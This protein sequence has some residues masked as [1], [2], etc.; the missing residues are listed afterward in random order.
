MGIDF[1]RRVREAIFGKDGGLTTEDYLKDYQRNRFSDYLPWVQYIP[2]HHCYQTLDNRYGYFFEITPF[3]FQ[4]SQ[5]TRAL[6]SLLQIDYPKKSIL[7]IILTPSVNCDDQIDAFISGKVR[8]DPLAQKTV[9]E[10]AN[11]LR[12]GTRGLNSLHG[13]PVRNFRAFVTLKT[14]EPL[15]EPVYATFHETLKN[16]G[17]AP[18]EMLPGSLV[19][20]A[21]ELFND[22]Y[23]REDETYD[24]YLPLRKQIIKADT[25]IDFTDQPFRVGNRYGA[26]LTPKSTRKDINPL[27]TNELIGGY[28]GLEDDTRQISCAFIWSVNIL[29]DDLRSSLSTKASVTLAQKAPGSFAKA[30]A[31]RV[32]EFTW[33]LDV[34]ETERFFTVI[35]S[36][37][38]LGDSKQQTVEMSSRVSNIWDIKNFT[39]QQE[40]ILAKTLFITSLPMGLYDIKNNINLLDRHFYMPTSALA[41]FMPVQ[42][43]FCGGATNPALLYIGRKGQLIGVDVFDDLSN[44][45]N[46]FCAA[47]SGS[48]KS[49]N[50]NF[51]LNAYY[52]SN[53]K[54][55]VVDLGG[56]YEKSAKTNKGRFMEFGKERT[57]INPF[58]THAIDKEDLRQDMKVTATIIAEMAYS[59]SRQ[60]LHETEWTL[61]KHAVEWAFETGQTINGIDAVRTFL[62]SFPKHSKE[63]LDYPDAEKM[64]HALAFNLSDFSTEGP[65][66][67]Y[68]NGET[69]FDIS[70]D[71]YV[72]LE[73]EKL[74]GDQELFNVIIMQVMNSV[75]QD[76]YLSDRSQRRFILFEEAWQYFQEGDQNARIATII[77]EG[78]RRARKYGGAFGIVVQSPLDLLKFG[79]IGKVINGNAAYKFFLESSDYRAAVEA[80]ILEY[81]GLAI[82]ILEKVKNVKPRYSEVF[83]QTPFG[84]GVARLSVDEWN[85]VVNSSEGKDRKAFMDILD[86]GKTPYEAIQILSGVQ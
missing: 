82:D 80:G 51:L 22:P 63:D 28:K 49:F 8:P 39:M 35:P 69:T 23:K 44:N 47:G 59:A 12:Q 19:R 68:F 32:E 36:L 52:A 33:A 85:R 58:H 48:G 34:A 24:L 75:T 72:V 45:Y 74:K 15:S 78:Y 71:D 1:S 25:V 67:R 61:I 83:I 37:V 62:G 57:V 56:S 41:R 6:E 79:P 10:Y 84:C 27:I 20:W 14:K 73:L 13:I 38:I 9:T 43:D 50:F 16:A 40:S 29:F 4:G 46:F 70:Q 53:A 60:K 77:E 31:K 7:Q 21:R 76:L 30:I 42:G 17:L 5:E 86:D 64:A 66:G 26:V 54:V 81:E 3:S 55:R 65:Y 11:Y 2:E 18:R